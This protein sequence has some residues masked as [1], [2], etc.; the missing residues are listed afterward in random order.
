LKGLDLV[1]IKYLPELYILKWW[2]RDE[3]SGIVQD[4]NGREIVENP[5][6]DAT[7]R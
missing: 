6:L 2:T 5:K 3:R 1:N 7:L 4:M